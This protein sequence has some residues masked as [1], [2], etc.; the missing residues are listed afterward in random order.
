MVKTLA[1]TAIFVAGAW[2]VATNVFRYY[3]HYT[4]EVFRQWWPGPRRFG[5]LLHITGGMVA[6]LIGPWQFSQR[7]RQ[8]NIRLHRW[9]GRT[10]LISIMLGA[11]GAVYLA[12]TTTLGWGW[13][14]ALGT[15]AAAWLTTSGMAFY[16][17]K[18]RMVQVHREWMVRSYIVTFGFVTF[19]MMGDIGPIARLGM[20]LENAITRVWVAWTVPLLAGEV[21]MQLMRIRTELAARTKRA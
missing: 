4:P 12:I 6:L 8:W 17:I 2:F 13:G 3:L 1:L 14:I 15:L 9:L 21:I 5:L 19:R 16:A 7:L 11:A 20:P 18:K 10:Y